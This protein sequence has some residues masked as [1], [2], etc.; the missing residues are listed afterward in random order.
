MDSIDWR[1]FLTGR[2]AREDIFDSFPP[3]KMGDYQPAMLTSA[4]MVIAARVGA[5]LMQILG[6]R[7]GSRVDASTLEN[8]MEVLGESMPE[9]AEPL[10]DDEVARIL[11]WLETAEPLPPEEREQ[12]TLPPALDLML[13]ADIESRVSVAQFAIA[14]EVDLELEYFD[15]DRNTWPRIRC[16]PTDIRDAVDEDMAVR[17]EPDE[18]E[19]GADR[20][21]LIEGVAEPVLVVDR[22]DDRFGIPLKNIRWLMPVRP[23]A[24][25]GDAKQSDREDESS[26]GGRLLDFPSGRARDG[27]ADGDDE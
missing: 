1:H 6:R 27:D 26:E 13:A 12:E 14:E 19:E 11:N 15:A 2:S 9:G 17:D 3:E 5:R 25:S 18:V 16:T 24:E 7:G 21:D 23:H 10:C 8:M 4:E 20:S 22:M